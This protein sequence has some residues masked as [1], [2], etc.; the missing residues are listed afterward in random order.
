MNTAGDSKNEL[1]IAPS[2]DLRPAPLFAPTRKAARVITKVVIDAT[3]QTGVYYDEGGHPVLGS[4]LVRDPKFAERV[5]AE[6]RA[7]LSTTPMYKEISTAS[8]PTQ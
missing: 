6:T 2:P 3:G 1:I 4:A 7:F 5:V 8:S